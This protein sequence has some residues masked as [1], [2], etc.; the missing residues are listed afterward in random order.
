MTVSTPPPVGGAVTVCL[1]VAVAGR[2][3]LLKVQDSHRDFWSTLETQALVKLDEGRLEDV[4]GIVQRLEGK[5]GSKSSRVGIL[6]GML[7]V[8]TR[9]FMNGL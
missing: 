8:R 7:L 5:F 9:A 6:K 1:L 4:S 3:M 2:P